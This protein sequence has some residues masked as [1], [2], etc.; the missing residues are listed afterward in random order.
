MSEAEVLGSLDRKP[1]GN[2]GLRIVGGLALGS[3]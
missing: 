2:I 3:P 1:Q